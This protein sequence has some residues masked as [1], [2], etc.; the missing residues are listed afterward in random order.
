M[1]N[2]PDRCS[3]AAN[4]FVRRLD[5]LQRILNRVEGK[6]KEKCGAANPPARC[7]NAPKVTGAIDALL[8][9]DTRFDAGFALD[10]VR[11]LAAADEQL[12]DAV[13]PE[14]KVSRGP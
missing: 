4:R 11:V 2:A 7:V 10:V 3:R 9:G 6:I 1:Q 14:A 12:D 13:H 8:A 5:R